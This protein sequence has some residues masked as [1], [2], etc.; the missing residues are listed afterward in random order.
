MVSPRTLYFLAAAAFLLV[1]LATTAGRY[2][3]RGRRTSQ[4]TWESLLK[5]LTFVDRNAIAE[6]ALDVVNPSGDQRRDEGS[7]IL[8]SS[9]IWKLIG[10]WDGV[11][12][13][14]ANCL[15]LIDLAF[16]VQQWHPEKA[17]VVAEQLRLSARE[18]EWH[19]QRL[20]AAAK[21]GKLET[22]ILM[23]AQRAAVTYFL[24][25]RHVLALY[26]HGNLPML[27]DLQQSL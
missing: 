16:Y 9:E 27:P 12:A 26:E 13:L 22:S 23:N 6:I 17:L 5:R 8:G 10:G 20:K 2:Y 15:V 19:V 24:M 25:T 11:E 4:A 1:F 14:E 7:A 18:I 3:L 21:A